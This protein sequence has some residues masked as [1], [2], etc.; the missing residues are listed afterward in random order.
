MTNDQRGDA[1]KLLIIGLKKK[2]KTSVGDVWPNRAL[3]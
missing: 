1:R 2:K 3:Q